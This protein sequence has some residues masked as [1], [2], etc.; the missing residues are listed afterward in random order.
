MQPCPSAEAG[1]P[2]RGSIG[3]GAIQPLPWIFSFQPST[4]TIPHWDNLAHPAE[5]PAFFVKF[6]KAAPRPT[7]STLRTDRGSTRSATGRP[8][9]YRSPTPQGP[10]SPRE[11]TLH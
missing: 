5:F 8:A 11:G 9:P 7:T 1:E 6:W 2:V 10:P 4:E 3:G